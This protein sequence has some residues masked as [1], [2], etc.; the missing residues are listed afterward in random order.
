MSDNNIQSDDSGLQKV[1]EEALPDTGKSPEEL[2]REEQKIALKKLKDISRPKIRHAGFGRRVA[3]FLLDAIIPVVTAIVLYFIIVLLTPNASENARAVGLTVGIIAGI[4]AFWIYNAIL[5]S[6]SRQATPGKLALSIRVVSSRRDEPLT[7]DRTTGRNLG[8]I[9]S[10][11]ILGIGFLMC[12]FT[13]NKQ[14]LHD[15]MVDCLVVRDGR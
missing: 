10:G 15:K 4:L 6:G 8:K 13:K 7:F 1:A 2:K 11:L 12:L 5:E 9:V 3:A 14:C